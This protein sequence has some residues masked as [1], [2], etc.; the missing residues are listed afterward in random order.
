M[1]PSLQTPTDYNN[2]AQT[3]IQNAD[4]ILTP[5]SGTT[6]APYTAYGSDLSAA[7]TGMNSSNPMTI[8]I[9]GDL[10]LLGWHHEG[11][12]LLLV[13]GNLNYD[14]DASWYGIVMVIGKGTVTGSKGGTGEFDGVTLLAQTVN[15]TTGAPLASLGG[16]N[17]QFLD[18]MGG[19]G[20]YYSSCWINN[21][22]PTASYKILSFHE[23]SQ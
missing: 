5:G 21:S 18:T 13:T 12:G 8:V 2:L 1:P 16:A 7:T 22:L 10:D 23:I 17:I 4:V 19:K 6:P 14:P 11:Y 15:P 3:I 9:R 20:F